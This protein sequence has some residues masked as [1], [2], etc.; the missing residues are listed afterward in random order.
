[1]TREEIVFD[2]LQ[3][4]DIPYT[5]YHHPEGKT[6]EEAKRWWKDDGRK[7]MA[8]SIAKTCFSAI[9]R[10]TGIIWYAS[11]ATMTSI[12]M[13][14]NTVSKQRLYHRDYPLVVNSR[15]RRPNA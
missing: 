3:Q 8:A 5:C 13:I 1:M 7:T 9:T 2:Y 11:I 4:H 15:L 6:I 14:W 12:F 10:E